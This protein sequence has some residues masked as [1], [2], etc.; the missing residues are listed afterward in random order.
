MPE[1]ILHRHFNVAEYRPQQAGPNCF[2]RMHRHGSSPSVRVPQENMATTG[3]NYS[4]SDVFEKTDGLSAP[5]SGKAR[6]T[7]IC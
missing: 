1:Q 4:E 5:Q 3:S 7:E 6:H 2:A